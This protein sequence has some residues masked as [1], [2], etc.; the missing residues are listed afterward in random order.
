MT[1]TNSKEVLER[2]NQLLHVQ[3]LWNQQHLEKY[4]PSH[5]LIDSCNAHD[6]SKGKSATNSN[7]IAKDKN[8]QDDWNNHDCKRKEHIYCKRQGHRS[9]LK[10][11]LILLQ[12]HLEPF[13]FTY[14]DY[15]R[16]EHETWEFNTFK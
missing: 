8:T 10:T 2:T 15:K 12:F 11:H 14:H 5:V 4:G 3:R 16:R 13:I 6:Y 7:F 1:Y 9:W